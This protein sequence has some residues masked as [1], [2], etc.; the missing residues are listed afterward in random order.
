MRITRTLMSPFLLPVQVFGLAIVVG[1]AALRHPA[2]LTGQELSWLDAL[3]T[4]TSAMCVTGLI[5]VDTGSYFSQL[6]QGV[7]LGLIQLGGLG[8]MTLASLFFYLWR[9]KVSLTDRV[10]VGRSLLHDPAFNLGSFLVSITVRILLTELAGAALLYVSAPQEFTPFSALFHAISAFCNAGFSLYSD[11]L[12][13]FGGQWS[14]NLVIMT[15][16]VL[17]GLGFSVLLEME[18]SLLRAMRERRLPRLSWFAGVVLTTSFALVALGAVFLYVSEPGTR[19]KVGILASLF[20][21]VTCRTAGFNTVNIAAMTE[22]SLVFMIALMFVGGSPGSTAG[23][24]KT[25]TFRVLF[26]FCLTQ[27]R[28]D[29]QTVIG[30]YA[31]D[32][33]TMNRAL[34]LIVFAVGIVGVSTLGLAITEGWGVPH[35]NGDDLFMRVLFESVSAFATVG[36]STGITPHL[37]AAGKVLVVVLMFVGRLGPMVLLAGLQSMRQERRYRYPESTMLIG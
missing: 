29:R 14:V 9:H 2:C 24:I 1:A 4:A 16:I 27:L 31:V 33:D 36:L 20:Q 35:A 32:Q 30:R 11:S 19:E 17:G 25:S 12:V 10:A 34:V 37:T 18:S 28:G 23:G 3:F 21:S 13:G 7:I 8:I 6:G 5:V 22:V 26:A 15:L